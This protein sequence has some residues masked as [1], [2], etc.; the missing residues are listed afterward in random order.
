MRVRVPIVQVPPKVA[1]P[2]LEGDHEIVARLAGFIKKRRARGYAVGGYVRDRILGRTSY[3]LDIAVTGIT[4]RDVAT[5]LHRRLGFSRPV[6]FSRS[7]TARVVRG[8]T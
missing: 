8:K 5:Y 1:G 2:S 4:P 7:R 6:I 3:D